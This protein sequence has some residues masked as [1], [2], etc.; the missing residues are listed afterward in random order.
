MDVSVIIV[1][2]NSREDL[3]RCIASIV[4]QTRIRYE[5]VV[6]D[7][8]SF[9]GCEAM[10]RELYP[11]VRFVQST[12]NL[13]FARAN[14]RAFD[15]S[16]GRMVL[17]LNP[18]TELVGRAIDTLA[19]ALASLPDA[20]VVGGTLLN[21]DRTIQSSCIQAFPTI[22]NQM[23]N[24]EFLRRRWPGSGL[25]GTKAL[26]DTRRGASEVQMISGA[27][28]MAK[29][30]TFAEVGR[31][32]EDYFMY[33]ED[34][35]LCFKMTKAGYRNYYV[36][37]AIVVHHGG[38]SSR[39]A[40]ST[41]AAVMMPEAIWRFLRKSRGRAYAALYRVAMF[42]SAIARLVVL[43]AASAAESESPSR[44]ASSRKWLAILRWSTGRDGIVKEYY[45]VNAA[46]PAPSVEECTY[47]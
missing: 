26:Y 12:V 40:V 17:F 2:W 20:G 21:S 46:V 41:F 47:R 28:L 13:G 33:A 22:F 18:D 34:A 27:C 19:E 30:T 39:Q 1:N 6:I 45:A 8:G 10:L 32:C 23:V 38:N 3:K 42:V 5:I 35:D 4:A 24:S 44:T 14:N 29:R 31:F 9:D 11:E 7:S 25:W 43:R 15:V 16:T 37:D 36:P